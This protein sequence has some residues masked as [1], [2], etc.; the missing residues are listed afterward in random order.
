MATP[1]DTSRKQERWGAGPGYSRQTTW[2]SA[3]TEATIGAILG[4]VG[5]PL[6]TSRFS[7]Y[8]QMAKNTFS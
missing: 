7:I 2:V 1:T 3:Q 8:A 6:K 4:D 5:I